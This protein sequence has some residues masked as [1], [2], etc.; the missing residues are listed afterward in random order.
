[1]HKMCGT[2]TTRT[3]VIF[4]TSR[5][6]LENRSLRASLT[7]VQILVLCLISGFI[8][9]NLT[10]VGIEFCETNA[11]AIASYTSPCY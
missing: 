8:S 6:F 2:I 5:P 10:S 7:A 3:C 9:F 1:M 4:S 11:E